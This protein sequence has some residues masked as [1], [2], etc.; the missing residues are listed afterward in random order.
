M[1][2]AAKP[3]RVVVAVVIAVGTAAALTAFDSGLEP[4][5]A[6]LVRFPDEPWF[7]NLVGYLLRQ[8]GLAQWH[9]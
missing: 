4:A 1:T 7:A 2:N 5:Q 9:L 6:L 8:R 3:E